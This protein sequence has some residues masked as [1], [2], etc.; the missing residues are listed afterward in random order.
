MLSEANNEPNESKKQHPAQ[1]QDKPIIEYPCPWEY[2]IIGLDAQKM[3]AAVREVI[4]DEAYSIAPSHESK[5][6]KYVSLAVETIVMDDPMRL[7][8]FASF[9]DH[10]DI[11]MVL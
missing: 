6:G 11:R 8:L 3:R 10:E 2:K 4:G 1:K 5:G 7:R 9:R